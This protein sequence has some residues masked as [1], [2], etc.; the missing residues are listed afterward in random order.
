M[1]QKSAAWNLAF[2]LV[3]AVGLVFMFFSPMARI[4]PVRFVA[5]SA[6]LYTVGLYVF[7][8]AKACGMTLTDITSPF[9]RSCRTR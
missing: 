7:V 6:A 4:A 1:S 8:A 9:H 3:P 2:L 5:V